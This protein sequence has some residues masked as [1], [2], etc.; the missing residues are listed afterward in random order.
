MPAI[1]SPTSFQAAPPSIAK[2]RSVLYY[3]L[4]ALAVGIGR[5]SCMPF[6]H[7]IGGIHNS[8]PLR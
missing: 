2:V 1:E 8:C 5:P 7:S 6:T 3:L 4:A